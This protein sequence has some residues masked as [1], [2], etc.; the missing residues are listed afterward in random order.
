MAEYI[1][2]EA[3][4]KA[5]AENDYEGYAIWAIKAIPAAD[6]VPAGELTEGGKDLVRFLPGAV[7]TLAERL[8]KKL[9]DLMMYGSTEQEAER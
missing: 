6:A 2:R 9:N 3:A 5:V 8:E 1:E 4:I 7:N